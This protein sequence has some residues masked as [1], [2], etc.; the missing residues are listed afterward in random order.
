MKQQQL[1]TEANK[2]LACFSHPVIHIYASQK[3]FV[4][5]C[6]YTCKTG[7]EKL[8]RTDKFHSGTIFNSQITNLWKTGFITDIPVGLPLMSGMIKLS[9]LKDKCHCQMVKLLC[10]TSTHYISILIL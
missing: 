3:I 1:E 9:L 5:M 2:I 10:F 6:A 4:C 8:K 7:A